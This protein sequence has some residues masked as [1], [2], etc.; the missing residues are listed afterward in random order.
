MLLTEKQKYCQLEAETE[1]EGRQKGERKPQ[2]SY[3]RK[4]MNINTEAKRTKKTN[5][6]K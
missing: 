2:E 1:A 3:T 6:M 5:K 4:Q